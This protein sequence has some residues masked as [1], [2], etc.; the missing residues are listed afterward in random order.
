MS[1]FKCSSLID[2]MEKSVSLLLQNIQGGIVS[3]FWLFIQ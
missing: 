3:A 2:A 1:V